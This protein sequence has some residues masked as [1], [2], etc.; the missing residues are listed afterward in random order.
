MIEMRVIRQK[1]QNF[2]QNKVHNLH[3]SVVA[4]LSDLKNSPFFGPPCI[5]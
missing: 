2:V 4:K 1:F 5:L 3:I